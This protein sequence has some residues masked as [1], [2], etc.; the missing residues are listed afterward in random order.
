MKTAKNAYEISFLENYSDVAPKPI[1]HA[2][3]L[4][5]LIG[6]QSSPW[7]RIYIEKSNNCYG[8]TMNDGLAVVLGGGGRAYHVVDRHFS[9]RDEGKRK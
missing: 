9:R 8:H 2:R 1:Y 6:N 7:L 3:T 5:I 4:M